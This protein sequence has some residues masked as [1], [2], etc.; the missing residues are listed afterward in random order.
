MVLEQSKLDELAATGVADLETF[1]YEPEPDKLRCLV[2]QESFTHDALVR[3]FKL[4]PPDGPSASS[5]SLRCSRVVSTHLQRDVLFFDRHLH[6]LRTSEVHVLTVSHV[7]D[8]QVSINQQQGRHSPQPL[9]VRRQAIEAPVL[10]CSGLEE[11]MEV[12]G[13]GQEIWHDYFSVPQWTDEL[14]NP[15]LRIIHTLYSSS[16]ATIIHF[17]DLSSSTVEKLRQD[18]DSDVT[19]DGMTGVC[20]AQWFQRM[21]TAMEFVSSSRIRMMTSDYHLDTGADDPAF[22]DR[23]HHVWDEE[24]VRQGS[25]HN[26][27]NMVGLPENRNLVPWTLGPLREVKSHK[28][29]SFAMAFALLARR[30]CRD[31][32]D[33]LHGL[34]GIVAARSEA[35]LQ[36]DFRTEYL[37]VARECLLAGDYSPLLMT[38]SVPLLDD[39]RLNPLDPCSYNEVWTWEL[40]E[41]T[42]PPSL[43]VDVSFDESGDKVTLTLER[44]GLVTIVKFP[45]WESTYDHFSRCAAFSL[46]LTGPN[47]DD[48][49]VSLGTRLYG[50]RK[51][52]IMEHLKAHDNLTELEE[53]LRDQYN[54]PWAEPWS[55]CGEGEECA[56]WLA[57]IMSLTTVVGELSESRIDLSYARFATMHCHPYN[58]MVGVTCTTCHGTFAFR[59][60]AFAPTAEL[61]RAVAYRV[62]GLKYKLSHLDGMG[63]LVK[64]GRIVGRMIWAS[65]ACEC[66]ERELVTLHMPDLPSPLSHDHH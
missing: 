30:K 5:E 48:F 20:N 23:L 18:E 24:V 35:A 54:T 25:V 58:Y 14:K 65:P 15:I 10:V 46:D 2:C 64:D 63:M 66:R 52:I 3:T 41:E 34:R 19:L 59:V 51:E 6:C 31:R 57:D 27:E 36:P 42:S 32:M 26:V 44:I 37:R 9:E 29:T 61:H 45:N 11:S 12:D 7:W 55:M 13:N 4:A 8:P 33:F 1:W 50:E 62:P 16:Y 53:L 38:P 40:G 43:P 39:P 21:W 49:V 28:T 60:G 22:L 56:E 47:L 17:N